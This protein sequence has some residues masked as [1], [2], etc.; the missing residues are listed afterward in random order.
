MK[1]EFV[2]E[3]GQ[4]LPDNH[5]YVKGEAKQIGQVE[6]PDKEWFKKQMKAIK[7]NSENLDNYRHFLSEYCLESLFNVEDVAITTLIKLYKDYH[8]WISWFIYENNYG[9]DKRSIEI[10]G[11]E[12]IVSSISDLWKVMVKDYGWDNEEYKNDK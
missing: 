1:N 4:K 2:N 5:P 10:D 6:M 12:I 3:I 7:K 8:E 11:E 9:E